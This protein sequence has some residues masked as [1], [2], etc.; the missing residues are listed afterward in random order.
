MRGFVKHEVDLGVQRLKDLRLNL[1]F[2]HSLK[3]L[4]FYQRT[5]PE[6]R[7]EDLIQA[8][9]DD[10][11]DMIYAPLVETI[12]IVATLSFEND[13]LQKC[14]QTKDFSRFLRYDHEPSHVA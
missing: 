1:S 3:R 12:P 4:R 13:Q 11:I 5:S 9:S 6:A 2:P 7:A 8:F 14:C 10:S